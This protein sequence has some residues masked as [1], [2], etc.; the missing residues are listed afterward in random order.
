MGSDTPQHRTIQRAF[1]VFDVLWELDGAGVSEAARELNLPKSTVHGYLQSLTSTGYVINE[2]GT[3][4]ISLKMLA[5]GGQIKYRNRLFHAS[6]GKL[7]ELARETGEVAN[8]TVREQ[9]S[10]VILHSGEGDQALD[11]GTFPGM[12]T[13]LHTHAAGKAILANLPP[14]TIDEIVTGG[15]TQM[16]PETITDEDELFAELETIRE[17]DYAVDWNEQIVGM[18]V[19]AAPILADS[20]VHGAIAIVCPSDRV[21][22]PDY[23]EELAT[24]VKEAANVISINYQYGR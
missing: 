14:E 3:Y 8:L 12:T 22:Q 6:R 9:Q 24:R 4:R 15:L 11:L 21:T 7:R 18:G 23:E 2:G 17:Q 13:P 10:A 20:E 19:V 1:E 5:K 16:T